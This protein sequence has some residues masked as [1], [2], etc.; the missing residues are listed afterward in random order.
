MPVGRLTLAAAI[1]CATWSIPIIR[2]AS[3]CGSTSTR[4]A[5]F[6]DPNTFTWATPV[7]IDRRWAS[8]FCAYRSSCGSGSVGEL[9]VRNST[10]ESAGFT[11]WYDGGDG[12]PGG[13]CRCARAIIDCTSCAAAS[14]DRLRSNCSVML[15]LP[16]VLEELIEVT[17][18]IVENC[19]SSGVATDAA[20]VS[21]LA[22]GR[23]AFTWIVGK[24]TVGR[25]LTGS[26]R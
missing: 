25:S 6:C 16:C 5:N 24:S 14:I 11:F 13:S 3:C 18:A 26:S 4:T 8:R 1:A 15:V 7:T 10:G 20:I 9:S 19:F 22:P 23:P 21:G 17:P 12:M 2:D